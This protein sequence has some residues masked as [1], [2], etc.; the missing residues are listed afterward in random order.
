MKI[1]LKKKVVTGMV[2]IISIL[3]IGFV[4][5]FVLFAM[6]SKGLIEGFYNTDGSVI[7]GSIAEKV[8]VNTNGVEQGMIIRGEN[9]DNP[10]IL[11]LHGGPGMPEYFL[12]EIYPTGIEKYFTVCWWEQRGAGLS[13][14]K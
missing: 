8:F 2:I 10:V 4:S 7:E 6:N 12:N 14:D 1:S 13:F 9:I 11:F 5:V 3:V